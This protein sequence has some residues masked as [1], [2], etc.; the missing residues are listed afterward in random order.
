MWLFF[1]RKVFLQQGKGWSLQ[2]AN[3]ISERVTEE[4]RET[5]KTAQR[6]VRE[7]GSRENKLGAEEKRIKGEKYD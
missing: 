5:W 2:L 7:R 1:Q 3:S 4:G 6:K